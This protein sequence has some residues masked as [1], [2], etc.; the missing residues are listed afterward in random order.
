MIAYTADYAN[1]YLIPDPTEIAEAAW[2]SV[3]SLPN[4]P[5]PMSISRWLIDDFIKRE[6][7]AK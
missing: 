2:F 3:D 6:T 4:I 5:S 7:V 1:G